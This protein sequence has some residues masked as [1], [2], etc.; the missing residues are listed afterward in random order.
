VNMDEA[1]TILEILSGYWP[2]PALTDEEVKAW[3]NEL[4]GR[5]M[6]ITSEEAGRVIAGFARTG[7]TFRLRPGQI[8]SEVQ[9]LRRRRALDR[10]VPALQ[11]A[12]DF[13]PDHDEVRRQTLA[14]CRAVLAAAQGGAA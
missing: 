7:S 2:T 8:V 14:R 3:L 9:A 11:S 4:C 5:H 1:D 10:P 12:A 6:R 13:G